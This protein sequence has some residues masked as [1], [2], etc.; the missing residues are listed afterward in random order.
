MKL[1]L[2]GRPLGIEEE[3][4]DSFLRPGARV[5]DQFILA[6]VIVGKIRSGESDADILSW[7]ASKS[8][9]LFTIATMTGRAQYLI[10]SGPSR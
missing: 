2:R 6:G 1:P 9:D 5:Y 8:E 3:L 7:A 10:D 4:V